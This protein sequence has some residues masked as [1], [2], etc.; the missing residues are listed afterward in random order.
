MMTLHPYNLSKRTL[1]MLAVIHTHTHTPHSTA[2]DLPLL[3]IFGHCF[4][5]DFI[6]IL[7]LAHY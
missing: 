7:Q 1:N 5:K 6:I 4:Q 2:N 3:K